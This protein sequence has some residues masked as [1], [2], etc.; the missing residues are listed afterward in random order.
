[1]IE[2]IADCRLPIANCQLLSI[3]QFDRGEPAF[4]CYL[5]RPGLRKSAIGNWKSAMAYFLLC[6]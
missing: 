1:M 5:P 6:T 3:Y 2:L 4:G